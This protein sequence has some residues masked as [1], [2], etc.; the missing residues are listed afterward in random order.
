MKILLLLFGTEEYKIG[1]LDLHPEDSPAQ[2][3]FSVA[4]P[5]HWGLIHYTGLHRRFHQT[6]A[7]FHDAELND[8]IPWTSRRHRKGRRVKVCLLYM[9]DAPLGALARKEVKL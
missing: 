6:H 1:M 4:Y 5:H 9:F 8:R 7:D 3:S 2:T